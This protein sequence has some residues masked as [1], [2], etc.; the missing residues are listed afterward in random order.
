MKRLLIVGAGHFGREV[1]VWASQ[2]PALG[3]AWSLAGFLDDNP[4]ALDGYETGQPLLGPISGHQPAPDEVFI[5]AIGKPST[6]RKVTGLLKG[7]GAVFI[8]L[9]HPSVIIG[10]NVALGEG[11]VICPN[12]VLTCDIVLGEQVMLNIATTVGHDARIGSWS[13]LSG[14][15]DITGFAQLGEEVFLGSRASVLPKVR[16]GDRAVVGAGAVALTNVPADTTLATRPSI[17]LV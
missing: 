3:K 10:R 6:K 8:T 16:V 2:S 13:T 15:C 17:R 7:R 1:L 9:V 4:R 5:C 14:H 11:C 12:C